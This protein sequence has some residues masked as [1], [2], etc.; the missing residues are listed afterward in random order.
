MKNP[1]VFGFL[2]LIT[3]ILFSLTFSTYTMFKAIELFKVIGVY[4]GMKEFLTDFEIKLF[5]LIVFALIYFML[6]LP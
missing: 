1:Y 6:F 4:N 2:P 3:I 5:V